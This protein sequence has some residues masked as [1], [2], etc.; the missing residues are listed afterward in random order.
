M[1]KT[2]DQ[3]AKS[4]SCLAA[5]T[6]SILVSNIPNW[7]SFGHFTGTIKRQLLLKKKKKTSFND[8]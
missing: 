2:E 7:S 6:V 5:I 1:I 8:R 3:K 4:E